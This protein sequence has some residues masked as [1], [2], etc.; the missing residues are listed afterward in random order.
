ML[1]RL[2]ELIPQSFA[3][4]LQEANESAWEQA[5]REAVRFGEPEHPQARGQ[6][7]HW[8][9]EQ[10]FRLAGER[11]GFEVVAPRTTPAGGRFSIVKM[12][13]LLLGRG[14]VLSAGSPPRRAKFRR[15]LA[16]INAFLHPCQLDLFK[17]TTPP[18]SD[19]MHA[20]V[21]AVAPAGEA[22]GLAWLGI[23]IPSM[24][25]GEMLYR[26]SLQQI[27]DAHSA[28]STVIVED[29]ARPV[30]K[31]RARKGGEGESESA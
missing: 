28:D 9:A 30:L 6:I 13:G 12:P 10:A 26:A 31:K 2:V 29:R 27:I 7:F 23:G 24:D 22:H 3:V 17:A 4:A 8:I 18:A 1:A 20:I 25:C 16:E 11:H 21:T 15:R 5:T 14:R 19:M